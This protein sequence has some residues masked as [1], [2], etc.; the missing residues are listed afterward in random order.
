MKRIRINSALSNLGEIEELIS[1][2]ADEFFAGVASGNH[3]RIDGY[4]NDRILKTSNLRNFQELRKAINIAER[5]DIKINFI[6]NARVYTKEHFKWLTGYIKDA[7]N[8]GVERF[9]VNCPTMCTF[10]KQIDQKIDIKISTLAAS[11]NDE[12]IRFY[13]KLGASS[14]VFPRHLTFKEMRE[15]IQ[16]FD[17]LDFEVLTFGGRCRNV[18]GLCNFLHT[19]R[20]NSYFSYL[21]YVKKKAIKK[22]TRFN[23]RISRFYNYSIS[24]GIENKKLRYMIHGRYV[25]CRL[26]Y[27]IKILSANKNKKEVIKHNLKEFYKPNLVREC[28]LC[29]LYYFRKMGVS[30]IK[31]GARSRVMSIKLNSIKMARK[32]LDLLET[33]GAKEDYFKQTKKILKKTTNMKCN[34]YNCYYPEVFY[35]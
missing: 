27:K 10:L 12:T 5:N 6:L 17:D 26:D 14:F 25:P 34:P 30:S 19:E 33:E 22:L 32:A 1:A 13:R 11:F 3:S 21:S 7:V 15:I 4:M 23:N 18:N 8:C 28:G 16:K 35:P 2:G 29:A 20:E 31:I 9:I 24:P